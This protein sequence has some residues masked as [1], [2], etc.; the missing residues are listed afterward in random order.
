MHGILHPGTIVANYEFI[1]WVDL[2]AWTPYTFFSDKNPMLR[3]IFDI[4]G[5]PFVDVASEDAGMRSPS[6]VFSSLSRVQPGH[7]K[8]GHFIEAE[9]TPPPDVPRAREVDQFAGQGSP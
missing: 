3:P 4:L 7:M 1:P 9:S 2:F 6:D 5:L 8:P